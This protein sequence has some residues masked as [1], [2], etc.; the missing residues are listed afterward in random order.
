[1]NEMQERMTDDSKYSRENP[2]DVPEGYFDEIEDRIEEK[3]RV[4][5]NKNVHGNKFILMVKPILGLAASFAL[6]F[7]LIYYPVTKILP[8][9][10][11]KQTD[12]KTDELKLNENFLSDYG[13]LDESTFFLALT[14]REDSA[15]FASDEIIAFLSSELDDYEVYS[16]IIN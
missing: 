3:I 12:K 8:K 6:A 16:E 11:T 5:E 14:S 4:E 15:N 1:M 2:F 10:L 9:F 7:L 13:Y